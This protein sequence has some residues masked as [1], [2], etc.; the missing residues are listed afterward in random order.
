M[1][2]NI[3]GSDLVC[4]EVQAATPS[5]RIAF[6]CAPRTVR[7]MLPQ[8]LIGAYLLLRGRVPVYV[9]RSDTCLRTR[10]S[11]HNH[12][13]PATHVTWEATRTPVAAFHLE[14]F[15]YHRH[16]RSLLNRIHPAAPAHTGGTCPF[17]LD[18]RPA[19]R[20]ALGR[21][22]STGH[23]HRTPPERTSHT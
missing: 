10:L 13:G 8:N 5:A 21:P 16:H 3:N 7:A 22:T 6:R 2:G 9:G 15:W 14:S 11:T 20:H 19:L 4:G 1:S 23:P 18:D 17:C 12:L